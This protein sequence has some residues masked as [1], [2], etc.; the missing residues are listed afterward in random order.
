MGSLDGWQNSRLTAHD[1]FSTEHRRLSS[2][3]LVRDGRFLVLLLQLSETFQAP[4]ALRDIRNGPVELLGQRF[5][6]VLGPVVR[7]QAA[8]LLVI[9]L[10]PCARCFR[11]SSWIASIRVSTSRA[12]GRDSGDENGTTQGDTGAGAG[13]RGT[14]RAGG[15]GECVLSEDVARH[16]FRF[17]LHRS[18][19]HLS[20][21]ELGTLVFLMLG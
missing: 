12:S 5:V 10:C 13:V 3:A 17:V 14:G 21:M 18:V 8:K 2:G 19:P 4:P 11:G 20:M 15:S 6:R 16:R 9:F 7:F 1:H